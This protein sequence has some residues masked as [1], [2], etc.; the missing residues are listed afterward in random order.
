MKFETSN[1][2]GISPFLL[3]E[4]RKELKTFIFD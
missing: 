1:T 2:G 4:A 3:T